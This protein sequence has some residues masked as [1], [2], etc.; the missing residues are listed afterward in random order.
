MLPSITVALALVISVPPKPVPPKD[1]PVVRYGIPLTVPNTP[2]A[3]LTL[4]GAKLDTATEVKADAG[5]VKSLPDDAFRGLRRFFKCYVARKGYREGDLG[6]LISL[7]AGLYPI[8]SNLRAREILR[9]RARGTAA[10]APAPSAIP[11]PL[12]RVKAAAR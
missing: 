4:R 1:Q 11:V 9:Q 12:P 6:F 3:K 10:E 8:L 5:A 2:K 7:M